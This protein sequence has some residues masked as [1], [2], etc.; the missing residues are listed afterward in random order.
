MFQ[1]RGL[2]EE[3]LEGWDKEVLVLRPPWIQCAADLALGLGVPPS[4]ILGSPE[5]EDGVAKG[6]CWGNG[7]G[8]AWGP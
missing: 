2:Q 6:P 8:A 7:G 1:D 4:F 3:G 5:Q